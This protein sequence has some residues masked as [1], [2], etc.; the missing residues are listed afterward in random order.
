MKEL[1]QDVSVVIETYY[2]PV[3]FSHYDRQEVLVMLLLMCFS[4]KHKCTYLHAILISR[5]LRVF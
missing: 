2:L 5:N 1:G 3:L 4:F